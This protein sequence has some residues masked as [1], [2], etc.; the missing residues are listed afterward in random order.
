MALFVRMDGCT[1]NS[2]GSEQLRL[3]LQAVGIYKRC[4]RY[5]AIQLEILK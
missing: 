4:G 2:R 1:Y 5:A 3:A